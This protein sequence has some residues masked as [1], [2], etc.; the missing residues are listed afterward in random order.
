M[1]H[2]HISRRCHIVRPGSLQEKLLSGL[3]PLPLLPREVM[4]IL[5]RGGSQQRT[6]LMMEQ[7]AAPPYVFL[8][9]Y[10]ALSLEVGRR[11]INWGLITWVSVIEQSRKKQELVQYYTWIAIRCHGGNEESLEGWKDWK[12]VI[13]DQKKWRRNGEGSKVGGTPWKKK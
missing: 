7:K 5:Q 3:R 9:Q 8:Q 10:P 11:Q 6:K 12:K 4:V 13:K 2:G 1:Y